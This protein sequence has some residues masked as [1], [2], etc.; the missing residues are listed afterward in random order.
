MRSSDTAQLF[1]EDVRVPA[2]YIIGDAGMGFT[3]QMMQ[4]Q[5]ERLFAAIASE[6]RKADEVNCWNRAGERLQCLVS[7]FCFV[8][9]LS[10]S[11]RMTLRRD[12]LK[13][14]VVLIVA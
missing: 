5:E 10:R 8:L 12:I 3:Y 2:S 4:F 14:E 1:L 7:E 11:A 9:H 6:S 13:L